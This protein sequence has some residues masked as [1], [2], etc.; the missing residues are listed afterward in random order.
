MTALRNS[1]IPIRLPQLPQPT[2]PTFIQAE[3]IGEVPEGWLAAVLCQTEDVG[4]V[5]PNMPDRYMT[6]AERIDFSRAAAEIRRRPIFAY[7]DHGEGFLDT[8]AADRL[9]ASDWIGWCFYWDDGE[10]P[11]QRDAR[12]RAAI[13]DARD[14]LPDNP[15]VMV[16]GAS[17]RGF[18]TP[19]QVADNIIACSALAAE[20][21][22]VIAAMWFAEGRGQ[23]PSE[24]PELVP[25]LD[26]L[27]LG[28]TGAPDTSP[29]PK[30]DPGPDP[31][32]PPDPKPE[33]VMLT[34]GLS[35]PSPAAIVNAVPHPDAGYLALQ[36]A[37]GK[38][39]TLDPDGSFRWSDTAGAWERFKDGGNLWV[40]E[41]DG[42]KT[43]V[44]V[45]G[46]TL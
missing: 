6:L 13:E 25:Y 2:V 12:Y 30:P 23:G 42:N 19:A 28:T 35:A 11:A 46:S 31:P 8:D 21:P 3:L 44:L 14:R 5:A 34:V 4:T 10:T 41:R 7:V 27:L 39:L 43:F 32:D 40:A 33:I 29:F 24:H 15:I 22:D 1:V 16:V 9:I 36:R 45:K 17:T 38:Y 26:A 18:L 37:D 20:Y